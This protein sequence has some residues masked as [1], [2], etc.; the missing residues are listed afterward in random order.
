MICTKI[1]H[2]IKKFDSVKMID[3][4]GDYRLHAFLTLTQLLTPPYN[5]VPAPSGPFFKILI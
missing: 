4:F 3:L 1:V 2:K 5:Q